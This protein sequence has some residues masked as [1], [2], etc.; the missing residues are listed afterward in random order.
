MKSVVMDTI[1]AGIPPKFGIILFRKWA[2]KFGGSLKIH[3]TYATILV[4][5]G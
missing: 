4:F 3:L 5:G 1:V 2:K